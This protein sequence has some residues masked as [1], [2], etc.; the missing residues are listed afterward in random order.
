MSGCSRGVLREEWGR[1]RRE[2]EDVLGEEVATASIP[3]G[4]YSSAVARAAAAE[5]YRALFTSEP[6]LRSGAVAGCRLLGRFTVA[7][8]VSAEAAASL[9]AGRLTPRLAQFLGWNARKTLK[10]VGGTHYL[11]LR[12][13]LLDARLARSGRPPGGAS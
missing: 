5:G 4:A 8:G 9:A 12:R 13:A 7:R 10:R 6:V 3:G 2:L 11:R 1:S